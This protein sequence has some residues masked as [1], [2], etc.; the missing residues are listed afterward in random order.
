MASALASV[1]IP[2][3]K[4][5]DGVQFPVVISPTPTPAAAAIPSLT[6]T[7]QAGK[8]YLQAWLRQSGAVLCRGFPVCSLGLQRR[9]PGLRLRRAALQ[10]G[11]APRT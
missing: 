2:Q 9:S 3:Q 4:L 10:L 11:T 6:K 7:I 8:H 5:Y 1:A